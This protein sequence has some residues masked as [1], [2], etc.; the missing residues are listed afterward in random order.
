MGVAMDFWQL[1]IQDEGQLIDAAHESEP[2]EEPEAM[3]YLFGG[4]M[5]IFH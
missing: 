4:A 2:Q 1:H 5:S 3:C